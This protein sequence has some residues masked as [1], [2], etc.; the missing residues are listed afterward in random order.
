M[1]HW[2]GSGFCTPARSSTITT[3]SQN[4]NRTPAVLLKRGDAALQRGSVA[5]A[6]AFYEELLRTVAEDSTEAIVARQRM[7]LSVPDWHSR[8]M[9]DARRNQA[10]EAAIRRA[11]KPGSR[12]LEIGTGA[13]LLAMMAARA[14]AAQVISCELNPAVAETA[15]EIVARNGLSERITILTKHS[16]AVTLEDLGG[17]VD[18][19]L[20]EIVDDCILGEGVLPAHEDAVARLLKP[21]GQVIPARG[22]VRVALVD[23]GAAENSQLG[24]IEGFDV[25]PFR[26]FINHRNTVSSGDPRTRMA[27]EAADLFS[28][29]LACPTVVEAANTSVDL[30]TIAGPANAIAHWIALDLDD[31]TRYEN[32]PDADFRSCWEIPL[33]PL[34]EALDLKHGESFTVH[35][36]HDR[37]RLSIWT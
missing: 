33:V 27:S 4:L 6:F 14:G 31:D 9:N 37:A 17:T 11:V 23:T 28:F 19:L 15:R 30:R 7:I 12:V 32:R 26:R 10:Y 34:A 3:I 1:R 20:S 21:G 29:D 18:V 24:W 8:M 5:R 16:E 22:T 2:P 36:S 25:R 35:A 13:G